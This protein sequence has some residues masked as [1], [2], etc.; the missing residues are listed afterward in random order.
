MEQV[1]QPSELSIFIAAVVR[2]CVIC[3]LDT[4]FVGSRMQSTQ[5]HCDKLVSKHFHIF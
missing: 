4:A 5:F 3:P 2:E 1:V